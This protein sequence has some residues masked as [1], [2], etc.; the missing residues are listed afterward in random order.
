M[1]TYSLINRHNFFRGQ[2]K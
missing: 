1:L 2:T